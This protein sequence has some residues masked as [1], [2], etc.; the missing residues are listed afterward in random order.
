MRGQDRG[1]DGLVIGL[2]FAP[3]IVSVKGTAVESRAN[4]NYKT[5]PVRTRRRGIANFY[6]RSGWGFCFMN[7]EKNEKADSNETETCELLIPA[8]DEIRV[9]RDVRGWVVISAVD[10][11]GN[12]SSVAIDNGD[13]PCVCRALRNAAKKARR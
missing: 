9:L 2:Y 1:D 10:R 5:S 3:A 7:E 4:A 8:S 6:P 12:E 13:V 11:F